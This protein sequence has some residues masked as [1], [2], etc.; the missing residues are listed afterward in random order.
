MSE[1]ERQKIQECKH[2]NTEF[3]K[4]IQFDELHPF[5]G[6]LPLNRCLNCFAV[7]DINNNVRGIARKSTSQ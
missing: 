6:V 3:F 5:D 2:E 1:L 4:W 7:L